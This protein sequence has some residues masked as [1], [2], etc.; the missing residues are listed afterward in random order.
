MTAHAREVLAD[1]ERALA[2]F[3]TGAATEFWRTRWVAV[4]GLL[5][6]VG[7]VLDKEDARADAEVG[8]AIKRAWARVKATKPEPLILWEFIEKERNNVVQ[9]Y[10]VGIHLNITVRPG[11][12]WLD[13]RTGETGGGPSGPTTRAYFFSGSPF[14]GTNPLELCR[15]AIAFWH[16]Y[17]DAIDADI[18]T[19]P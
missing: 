11:T 6:A 14:G 13:R 2:D 17:L 4:V 7:H 12:A 19:A 9:S 5:R 18:T 8:R 10:M 3:E 16:D 1:C 15:D